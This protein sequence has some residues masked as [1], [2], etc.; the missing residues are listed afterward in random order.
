[1]LETPVVS[2]VEQPRPNPFCMTPHLLERSRLMQLGKLA[3]HLLGEEYTHL[4]YSRK[5][6][7]KVIGSRMLYRDAYM[8]GWAYK[9]I[10]EDMK[11]PMV[12]GE[13]KR[14]RLLAIIGWRT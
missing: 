6:L 9:I 7:R 11:F 2:F 1:M 14:S 5:P 13:G 3:P 8:T 10:K 4:E 12:F